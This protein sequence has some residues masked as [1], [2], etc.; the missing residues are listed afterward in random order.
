[1]EHNKDQPSFTPLYFP[2]ELHRKEALARDLEY[3]YGE[4]WEEKIQ[5]SEATQRY[6]DRI[7]HVGQH[8]PELLVSHAYTRYMG[9]LSG[10]QVLKRVAQRALKLPS[11]GEGINFYMFE[12]ISNPQQFKQFYRA[13]LNALDVSQ[14][15]KERIVKE[16]NR[17]FEFNMQVCGCWVSGCLLKPPLLESILLGACG[18]GLPL[19]PRPSA[20]SLL[21]RVRHISLSPPSVL[22]SQWCQV[23]VSLWPNEQHLLWHVRLEPTGPVRALEASSCILPPADIPRDRP[24]VLRQQSES[25]CARGCSQGPSLSEVLPAMRR[26]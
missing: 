14:E 2:L 21:S 23:Q 16:A 10:G 26:L 6:V 13:R 15:T 4:G 17:A 18:R 9:D 22:T 25:F 8:E 24:G 12:N 20:I 3:L 19:F 5:C 7:H 1:M 11:T